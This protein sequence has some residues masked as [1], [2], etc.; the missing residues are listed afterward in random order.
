MLNTFRKK[1]KPRLL[2]S[3]ERCFLFLF[4][5]IY[6]LAGTALAQ[7]CSISGKV[8]D[9][10]T[11]APLAFVNFLP[12]NETQSGS[13]DIDGKFSFRSNHSVKQLLFSYVGYESYIFEVK[14]TLLSNVVIYMKQKQIELR[15]AVVIAGENP[16]HRIIRRVAQE[17]D[18]NDPE[19]MQSFSYISYNKLIFTL[20]ADSVARK[21]SVLRIS[22]DTT[23]Q[24]QIKETKAWVEKQYF[25]LME[26]ISSRNFMKPDRNNETVL[27]SRV[28]GFQDPSFILL[29]TQL[30]SFSFYKDVITINDRD[31]I[32]PISKGSLSKYSYF[33]EDTTYNGKDTIFIIS[34]RPKPNKNF[35]ALKG[36]LYINTNG[37]A[38]QNVIAEPD[39]KKGMHIRIQQKY[40]LL[41]NKQWFPTQLNTDITFKGATI[42]T[43]TPIGI[44]RTYIREIV[45]DPE[46]K[47]KQFNRIELKVADDAS[48]QTE[49][50]WNK[51]RPDTLS[52]M[53][54][55]TY[56]AIDSIGKKENFDRKLKTFEA[57]LSGKLP[58]HF[59]DIDLRRIADYN[60]YEGERIGIGA[61][62]NG[63]V[64]D[65]FSI[66]GYGAY[67]F[68]DKALKYG[69]D[70][71]LKPFE[72]PAMQF[73]AA[74]THDVLESGGVSFFDDE[75]ILDPES[76]R[77]FYIDRMDQLKKKE[78]SF[79][80]R[81][82]QYAKINVFADQQERDNQYN[83][84]E[85][86]LAMRYAFREKFISTART[87]ISEGTKYPIL[88]I[89][90]SKGLQGVL[91]GQFDYVKIDA[92]I[93][94]AFFIPDLGRPSFQLN[95]GWVQGAV[96]A[97]LLNNGKGSF[98][99]FSM[100]APLT[101]S[102]TNSFETM[103]VNEFLSSRYVSL[104][105][106]HNFGSRLFHVR[107]F[108]PH[109]SIV[110][111]VEFGTLDKQVIQFNSQFKTLEK[112]YYESG[113][114]FDNLLKLSF[115]R[116]GIGGFYRYG[117]YGSPYF[118]DNSA[119]K[120]TAGFVF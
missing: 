10:K 109:I 120:L 23:A 99:P 5:L 119:L 105:A 73:K 79:T 60:S 107:K 69:S 49:E 89:N 56:H 14:D 87:Q 97:T 108:A 62:T 84:T 114:V 26:S 91:N 4:F 38:I 16:I 66:G 2:V 82:L 68:Q 45:L 20:N 116:F 36:V 13:T 27:A 47:K 103:G 74:Y 67:G 101:L 77:R 43:L 11:K 39:H 30:Q 85:F 83:F 65:Y 29:A 48:R 42:N 17:K 70:L 33:M 19:K 106:T 98:V 44:G 18:K 59:L 12:S 102:A 25:F 110:S 54:K 37:Y 111:K 93:E 104:F 63:K 40:E 55:N 35:D 95:A 71:V 3:D 46:L 118:R 15:E 76:Y 75:K 112:G 81:A 53:E 21:D 7:T 115:M 6:S 61:H 72:D 100:S 94:K 88:W 64:S 24:K 34:F 58:W 22:K 31:Y 117:P 28:S 51:Y 90:V 113:I 92:K 80:F 50:F 8:I 32:N 1:R 41:E 57:L 78:L 96:P 52:F 9:S 86:G